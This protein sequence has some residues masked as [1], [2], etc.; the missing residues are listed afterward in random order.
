MRQLNAI[1]EL[2]GH[3]RGKDADR[4]SRAIEE[5]K[6]SNINGAPIVYATHDFNEQPT[7]VPDFGHD[8]RCRCE[9]PLPHGVKRYFSVTLYV[10]G[11]PYEDL[12]GDYEIT[13]GRLIICGAAL[14]MYSPDSPERSELRS[15][16]VIQRAA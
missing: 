4:Y 7:T 3:Y 16:A 1:L 15:I 12:F 10:E 8:Y 14:P 2:E 11:E 5:L 6:R 13:C 9:N